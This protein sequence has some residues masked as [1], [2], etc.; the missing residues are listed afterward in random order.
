MKVVKKLPSTVFAAADG[1]D[2]FQENE[3]TLD[4][5]EFDGSRLN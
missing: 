3:K 4:S 2:C 1:R 5:V